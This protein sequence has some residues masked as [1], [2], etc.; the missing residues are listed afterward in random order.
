[1]VLLITNPYARLVHHLYMTCNNILTMRRKKI[2]II[3]CDGIFNA[4][5]W[6]TI[7]LNL[8]GKTM[9]WPTIL[10]INSTHVLIPRKEGRICEI[11]ST[12]VLE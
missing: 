8:G 1:M 6:V 9:G 7:F 4:I 10:N 2:I 12:F 5:P 3:V 11:I